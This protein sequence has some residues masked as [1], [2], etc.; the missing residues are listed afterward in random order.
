MR[1]WTSGSPASPCIRSD[2]TSLAA[3]LKTTHSIRPGSIPPRTAS[4]TRRVNTR[5]LPEPAGA[6][7]STT[8][9]RGFRH[10]ACSPARLGFGSGIRIGGSFP[11]P[12]SVDRT[13]STHASR[14]CTT[15]LPLNRT[16]SRIPCFSVS[17]LS[18]WIWSSRTNALPSISTATAPSCGSPSCGLPSCGSPSCGLPSCGSPSCGLPSCGPSTSGSPTSAST[19]AGPSRTWSR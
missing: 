17:I 7:V 4:T 10:P 8:P 14:S 9:E 11:R 2:I 3:L 6:R 5:V 19:Q 1:I 15:S 18:R 16:T 13:F 12:V